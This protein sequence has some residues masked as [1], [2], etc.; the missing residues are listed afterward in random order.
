M[1]DQLQLEKAIAPSAREHKQSDGS[2]QQQPQP[3]QCDPRQ[4][5][6]MGPPPP[7]QQVQQQQAVRQSRP[8]ED[9]QTVYVQGTRYTKLECVGRG[10]SSK[11]FKVRR[12]YMCLRLAAGPVMLWDPVSGYV[13]PVSISPAQWFMFKSYYKEQ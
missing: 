8:R 12:G 5:Q 11:V 3:Q 6:L 13:Y 9:A 7:V 4:Q 2:L 1:L 10:G